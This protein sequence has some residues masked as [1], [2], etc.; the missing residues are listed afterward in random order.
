MAVEN[1]FLYKIGPCHTD[2]PWHRPDP[3]NLTLWK[4]E[5][6][7]KVLDFQNYKIWLLG[8]ALEGEPTWDVDFIITGALE[9]KDKLEEI[10]TTMFN[11]GF[12]NRVLIDVWWSDPIT[13][14]VEKGRLCKKM[15]IACQEAVDTGYC[16]GK[17]CL[18]PRKIKEDFIVLSNKVT[19]NGKVLKF[20][21]SAQKIHNNLWL[22]EGN[23]AS[24]S[25]PFF[26]EKHRKKTE[27]TLYNKT[28][29]I[30]LSPDTNFY[31]Y[32]PWP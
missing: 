30:L 32:I 19:K 22:C 26:T 28:Y 6:F 8:A 13:K 27:Q 17:K 31:D 7:E 20:H 9:N 24:I 5:L 12:N 16:S 2:T 10:M 29:P 18:E 4:E 21:K 11:I 15:Q 25:D 14:H 1:K 23:P 3:Y